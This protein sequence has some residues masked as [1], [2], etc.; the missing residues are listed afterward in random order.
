MQKNLFIAYSFPK[1]YIK[2]S[3]AQFIVVDK[4]YFMVYFNKFEIRRLTIV[5]N[6]KIIL[7][8]I[9]SKF[10]H[11]SPALYYLKNSFESKL[12]DFEGQVEIYENSINDT[13]DHILYQILNAEPDIVGFSVYIW[14]VE[15]ITKLCKSIKAA[16]PKCKIILGGP[17]VSY[18]VEHTTLED[19][20]FDIIISGE[21]EN[22]FCDAVLMLLSP[23]PAQQKIIAAPAVES[24]DEIP[25]IYQSNNL[26]LFNNKIIYYESSRGC[27]F[28]CAY[29]LSS[30][31]GKVRF[32]SLERVFSDLD[33][34]IENNVSQV[35]F[36]DR[37]FNCN[38]ERAAKIWAYILERSQDS[39]T[40]FHFEIG[41]DLLEK[42]HIELLKK[43]P[44]GKIQLEIGIQSTNEK[45]LRESCRYAPTSKILQ[46]IS[47]ISQKQNINIHTDLIAGLP[48]EDL[49][50]FKKSFNEVYSL[51]SN[52]LQLGFL[53]L[54]SGAP[55]NNMIEKHGYVFT[56]YPPYEILKNK[57]ISFE[58]LSILKEVEDALERFYNSSRFSLS[59][60]ELEKI[61]PNA[62]EMYLE[63]SKELKK[64]KL[65]FAPVSTKRLYDFLSNFSKERGLNID[66][67][68]LKDFYLSE[69]SEIPP[70]SL[71]HLVPLNKFARPAACA[72]LKNLGLSKEK[73]IFVKFIEQTALII[74]YSKKDAVNSRY[75]LKLVKEAAFELTDI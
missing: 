31:C 38:K 35:K 74:D 15:K 72:L 45:T 25:F 2:V 5:K 4:N 65:L 53:K 60:E 55:L 47:A 7:A 71:K 52:Q 50:S 23:L 6:I 16:L 27:P 11:S 64:L 36:V 70:E 54:L 41:A 46:N 28:N 58:E 68:L 8:A 37:T 24:L 9:H 12:P 61:F 62:F 3:I 49:D 66:K 57:Y 48:Y 42:S 73:K 44:N 19:K 33:F 30:V 17:E 67:K 69:N 39:G 56:P 14:N 21:G 10:I 22:A 18:G 26:H 59:L 63:I 40:N 43:F 32:L 34:F 75:D 1:Q 29:C 20:D 51:K 13:T